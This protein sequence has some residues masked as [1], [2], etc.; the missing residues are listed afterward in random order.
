MDHSEPT[1][2]QRRW[3]LGGVL[4]AFSG[5]LFAASPQIRQQFGWGHLAIVAAL[6]LLVAVFC[7][8][9]DADTTASPLHD[10]RLATVAF[11]LLAI[12]VVGPIPLTTIVIVPPPIAITALGLLCTGAGIVALGVFARVV[13]RSPRIPRRNRTIIVATL[14]VIAT[15]NLAELV[16][17]A[18]PGLGEEFTVNIYVA[19]SGLRWV[20]HCF[21][22]LTIAIAV[23]LSSEKT[24]TQEPQPLISQS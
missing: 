10:R 11:V 16:V 24:A 4:L 14:L 12:A 15:L 8:I 18:T 3:Q 17:Q 1:T 9:R 5:M 20:A 13:H 7:C 21:G 19:L 23:I 22:A 2:A 6:V